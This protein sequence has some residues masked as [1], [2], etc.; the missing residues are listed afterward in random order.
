MD[1][2]V[3][4][5]RVRLHQPNNTES[6]VL[7]APLGDLLFATRFILTGGATAAPRPF[8]ESLEP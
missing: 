2:R 5:V 6:G 1:S 7:V 8:D 4:Q 3:T